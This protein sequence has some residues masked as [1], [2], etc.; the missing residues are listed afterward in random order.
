VVKLYF[1]DKNGAVVRVEAN[2]KISRS[3]GQDTHLRTVI[4]K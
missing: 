2:P 4:K 1:K 3:I